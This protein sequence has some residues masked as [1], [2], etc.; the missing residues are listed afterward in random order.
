MS[1]RIQ[2]T[3]IGGGFG[4]YG[5]LPALI[6]FPTVD[7]LL[8][9]RYRNVLLARDDIRQYDERIFWHQDEINLLNKCDA[10]IM[11]VPPTQQTEWI[12]E[13]V[14]S[15]RIK[16][17]LL[18]KPLACTPE[19]SQRLLHSLT[20]TKINFRIG[21]NFRYTEWGKKLLGESRGA[22]LIDWSFQAHHF[23]KNLRTWKR[24]H[25]F[26]GGA[27][28]F[29]G[30]HIIALLAELGYSSAQY[31]EFIIGND[32]EL[33]RWS[34]LFTGDGLV[35]CKVIVDSNNTKSSFHI[36]FGQ[37]NIKITQPFQS[38]EKIDN[39]DGRVIFLIKILQDL[40]TS[41]TQ[42]YPWYEQVNKLWL[43]AENK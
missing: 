31:S 10:V 35:P 43:A 23:Q 16:Y 12:N 34:S 36:I 7:I 15:S 26:G 38:E 11:A 30:I 1:A 40:F 24:Y 17:L 18:E 2:A 25:N 21:Y 19:D 22:N 5:Y 42:I 33:D 13:I 39:A 32:N 4:L 29:Y 3:I 6:Q 28:R 37:E 9:S 14:S 41:S 20:R 8:P 27:L